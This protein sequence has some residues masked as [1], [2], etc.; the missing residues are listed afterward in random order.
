MALE[1]FERLIRFIPQSS[2]CILVGQPV[3]PDVDVGLAVYHRQPVLVKVFSGISV[4]S[5]GRPTE[6]IETVKTILSPLNTEEVG[7]IRCIGLN[8]KQHAAEVGMNI[9]GVPTVFLKPATAL[10]SPWPQRIHLPKLTHLDQCGDYEAELAVVIGKPVKNVDENNASDYILGYTAANDVSS[11]TSQFAQSQWCFSKGFDE[12]C[13]IGKKFDDVFLDAT[14][15]FFPTYRT[16]V[17]FPGI[18]AGFFESE[19][20]GVEKRRCGTRL[21]FR[22]SFVEMVKYWQQH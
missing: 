2:N 5:P 12:S 17:S 8:Y 11:R 13:P 3:D 14:L 9:P 6:V 21:P 1:H 15:N 18:A 20:S 22:V 4:L 16:N 7:S 10:A 19:D